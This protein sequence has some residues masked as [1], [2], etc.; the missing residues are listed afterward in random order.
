MPALVSLF[1]LLAALA[2]PPG[3]PQWLTFGDALE[4]GQRHDQKVLVSVTASWCPWCARL[5]RVIYSDPEVQA[6]LKQHFALGRIQQDGSE[7]V[8]YRGRSMHPATV[9][10]ALGAEAVP[11]TVFFDESGDYIT[12]YPGYAGKAEFLRLLRYIAEDAYLHT[13][14]ESFVARGG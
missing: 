6:Y 1:V 2:V 11:G 13:S 7:P 9:A 4:E 8:T 10:F 12:V 3:G 5:D 14:F